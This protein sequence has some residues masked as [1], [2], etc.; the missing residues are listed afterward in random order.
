M[1]SDYL[2]TSIPSISSNEY[3]Y[4]YS[5]YDYFYFDAD[6][7][8]KDIKLGIRP[9]RKTFKGDFDYI[10]NKL[11]EQYSNG[12]IYYS[13]SPVIAARGNNKTL[14]GLSQMRVLDLYCRLL[15]DYVNYI[16]DD[17]SLLPKVHYDRY[18]KIPFEKFIRL[19]K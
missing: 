15:Q 14:I 9:S 12:L 4:L 5:L 7:V 19:Y 6:R 2:Y 10:M 18:F 1:S 3:R 17:K 8:Y 16:F 13:N 11:K